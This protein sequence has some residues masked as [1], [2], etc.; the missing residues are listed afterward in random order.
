M[1]GVM[2]LFWMSSTAWNVAREA[3]NSWCF[4]I[5]DGVADDSPP[6][7]LGFPVAS[8]RPSSW[9]TL[10]PANPPWSRIRGFHQY[11]TSKSSHQSERI[12]PSGHWDSWP[13]WNGIVQSLAGSFPSELRRRG[14]DGSVVAVVRLSSCRGFFPAPRDMSKSVIRDGSHSCHCKVGTV[15]DD[16]RSEGFRAPRQASRLCRGAG[17]QER[18]GQKS[19]ARACFSA[20]WEKNTKDANSLPLVSK[21]DCVVALPPSLDFNPC[22]PTTEQLLTSPGPASPGTFAPVR[23]ALPDRPSPRLRDELPR[24]ERTGSLG[25]NT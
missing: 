1:T 14:R 8:H 7:N 11:W 5:T 20:C 23:R 19:R 13:A 18:R 4:P 21:N 15:I 25:S 9:H 22:L 3:L 10:S 24:P 12:M 2:A 17:A 6:S 16:G